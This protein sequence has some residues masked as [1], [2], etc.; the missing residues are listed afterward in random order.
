M[1]SLV[2]LMHIEDVT[3]PLFATRLTVSRV[4]SD[5]GERMIG[6]PLSGLSELWQPEHELNPSSSTLDGAFFWRVEVEDV[7]DESREVFIREFGEI[8]PF[9]PFPVPIIR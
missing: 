5:W 9:P 3:D 1:D 8:P 7:E 2:P 4:A 6:T